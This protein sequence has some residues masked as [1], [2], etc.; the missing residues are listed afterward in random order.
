MNF[1]VAG[2]LQAKNLDLL[3]PLIKE[4]PELS[5]DAE[6]KLRDEKD[7]LD[8]IAVKKYLEKAKEIF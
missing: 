8:F 2:G 6:G 5:I 7:K 3:K 4:F 1:T